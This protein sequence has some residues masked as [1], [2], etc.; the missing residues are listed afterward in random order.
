MPWYSR[1]LGDGMQAFAPTNAIQQ[2]FMNRAI[3]LARAGREW[4]GG[5]A[6]F[7]RYDLRRNVV[8]AYITP[9][10][11]DLAVIL[12]FEPCDKPDRGVDIH[13]S[14]G[15]LFGT[16]TAWEI[17]FPREEGSADDAGDAQ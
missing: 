1:E 9:E 10:A 4:P 11:G 16:Q 13:D 6:L 15:M 3:E 7:S 12:G 8:T 5:A 17:H 14:I 2:I